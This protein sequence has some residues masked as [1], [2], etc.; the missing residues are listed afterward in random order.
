MLYNNMSYYYA[1]ISQFRFIIIL[2]WI[3]DIRLR[4][5]QILRNLNQ[6]EAYKFL[7]EKLIVKYFLMNNQ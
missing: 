2:Q 5:N 3:L 4:I 1:S 7:I 6:S